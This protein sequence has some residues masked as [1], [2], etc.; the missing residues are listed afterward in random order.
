MATRSIVPLEDLREMLASVTATYAA[1]LKTD[2]SQYSVQDRQ[3]IKQ[4]RAS[5][6]A[7]MDRVSRKI[8][9]ADPDVN[10]LG[11]NRVDFK[12]FRYNDSM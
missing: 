2:L 5:M 1:S 8:G 9:L 4:Q 12:N 7:E 3:M 11:S 6:R 10:A